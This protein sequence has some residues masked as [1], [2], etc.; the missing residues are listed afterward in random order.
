MANLYEQKGKS[1]GVRAEAKHQKGG[2]Q[3][4]GTKR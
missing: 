1:N 4:Y 3:Q 2:G